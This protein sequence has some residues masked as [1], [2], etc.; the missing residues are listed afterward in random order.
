MA[1]KRTT[2]LVLEALVCFGPIGLVLLL[3]V[4]FLPAWVSMLLAYFSDA[5]SS[6]L[7]EGPWVVI[8]PMLVVI[9]GVIGLIGLVRVLVLLSSQR[10]KPGGRRLTLA[11]VAIGISA[12]LLFHWMGGGIPPLGV[13]A[14][15]ALLV[16][17]ILP[18]IG[19]VH[20]LFLA[21]EPLLRGVWR[22]DDTKR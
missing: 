15:P 18:A 6:G 16:Y 5:E 20:F 2:W 11:M 14:V 21:R 4:I 3:G 19:I 12:L 10:A 17:W 8:R 1:K 13:D 7:T 22:R 9:G